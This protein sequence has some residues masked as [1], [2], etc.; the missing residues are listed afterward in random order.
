[1]TGPQRFADVEAATRELST[2]VSD[3][4]V[5]GVDIVL[6]LGTPAL[7][8]AE[9]IAQRVGA[10]PA[11][12]SVDRDDAPNV[13]LPPSCA[14]GTVLVVDRGVETGQ[15]AMLAARAVRAAGAA[16]VL[17]AVAVCPRQAEWTLA[18]VYDEIIAVHRPLGRR[19]LQW[20]F[21]A[22]LE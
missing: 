10:H 8:M 16:R 18:S 19:S 15:A 2:A 22:P 11:L 4:V 1:M 7:S 17:L 9:A 21:D 12:L 6:A 13:G 5:E 3:R 14:G 20:H